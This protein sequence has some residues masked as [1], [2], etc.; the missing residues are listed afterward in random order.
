MM[1]VVRLIKGIKNSSH[2]KHVRVQLRTRQHLADFILVAF[3]ENAYV[4]VNAVT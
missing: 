2:Q 4:F 1:A 3:A